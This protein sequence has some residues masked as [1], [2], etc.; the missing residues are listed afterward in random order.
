MAL[1]F[2]QVRGRRNPSGVTILAATFREQF[3]TKIHGGF[4]RVAE[5]VLLN[6][7][8]GLP[9]G[10]TLLRAHAY[11]RDANEICLF[12]GPKPLLAYICAE[13]SYG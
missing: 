12:F 3:K 11:M 6:S 2:L 13:F 7:L 10:A 9:L 1:P 8:N 5:M 4:Y